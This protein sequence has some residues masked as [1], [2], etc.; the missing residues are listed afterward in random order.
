MRRFWAVVLAGGASLCL[1]QQPVL[2]QVSIDS[3][4]GDPFFQKMTGLDTV[5]TNPFEALSRREVAW[6]HIKKAF[7]PLFLRD[8][9]LIDS[10]AAQRAWDQAVR[11]VSEMSAIPSEAVIESRIDGDFEGWEGET[12]FILE[13]GQIWKQSRYAYHYHY[14]FRPKVLIF[15][16]SAGY[17]MKVDGVSPT[18]SV[19]RLK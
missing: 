2:A 14:A 9:L 12:V 15:R 11:L 8:S 5:G 6:L 18:V 4:L 13:N 1:Y 19:E 10:V 3:V 7:R 16:G 17:E